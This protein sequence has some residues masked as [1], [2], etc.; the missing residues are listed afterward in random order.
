[1]YFPVYIARRIFKSSTTGYSGALVKL[2]IASIALSVAVMLLSTSI[3]KGFKTEISNKIYGFWGNIHITDTHSTRNFELRPIDNIGAL[4]D[5]IMTIGRLEYNS[6]RRGEPQIMKQT[7]G[8]VASISPFITY[9]SIIS[10]KADLEAIVLKGINDEYDQSNFA[11]YVREGGF[12]GLTD[13]VASRSIMISEQTANRLKIKL[14]DPVNIH[15]LQDKNQIKRRV[16]VAGLYRT[17]LE[18]YDKKFAF[19][20]MRLIQQVVGW[21]EDQIIGYEISVDDKADAEPIADYIYQELLPAGLYAETIEEKQSSIF[22]WLE[23]QDIN[24]TMI[25]FLMILVAIINMST[26]LLILILERSKMIGILKSLGQTDWGVR[27]IFILS[28]VYIICFALLLGN[29]LGL[30]IGWLQ[31]KIGFLKLDEANYYLSEVPIEFDLGSILLI[32]LGSIL[33][34]GL[35]MILPSFIITRIKPLDI[36][37]FD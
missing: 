18:E 10:T 15:F 6:A 37:R 3:I 17:G 16:K 14:G 25:L 19:V 4:K 29:I 7:I 33:V 20:D 27:M 32:N 28:A 11:A 36:I 2:A 21:Q 26:G 5:S 1:M 30:G 8:G 34:C 9:P 24:E 13:S 35:F 23:L 12:I 22:E 31:K